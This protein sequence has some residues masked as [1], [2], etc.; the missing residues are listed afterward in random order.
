MTKRRRGG[1]R[2]SCSPLGS[3]LSLGHRPPPLAQS[4]LPLC[5]AQGRRQRRPMRSAKLLVGPHRRRPPLGTRR[6]SWPGWRWPLWHCVGFASK[7]LTLSAP[8]G[9]WLAP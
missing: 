9:R 1:R 5:V 8:Q 3:P 6:E 7:L 2:R 4:P